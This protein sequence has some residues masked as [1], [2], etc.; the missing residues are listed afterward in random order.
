MLDGGWWEA[1]DGEDA[2]VLDDPA[3]ILLDDVEDFGKDGA[4]AHGAD[5]E[6]V[7]PLR[8]LEE[9]WVFLKDIK[10]RG[11]S[12]RGLLCLHFPTVQSDET[13]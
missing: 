6:V 3:I 9:M 1:E 8:F 10:V 4:A 12:R 11:C 7:V 2:V 13:K 5:G